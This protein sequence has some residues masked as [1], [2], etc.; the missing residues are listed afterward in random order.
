M[1]CAPSQS[2]NAYVTSITHPSS[3]AVPHIET[4]TYNYQPG[5][6]ATSVDQNQQSTA[7]TYADSFGRLTKVN[8][9]DGGNTGYTYN[10]AAT[11]FSLTTSKARDSN[12]S[13]NV[14]SVATVTGM[15]E[16]DE[17]QLTSDPSGTDE[18]DTVYDGLARVYTV[19]NPYRTTSDSTY[20]IT[21]TLYDALGRTVSVTKPDGGVVGSQYGSTNTVGDN[22]FC[23]TV[24]DEAGKVRETCVDGLGRTLHVI[25]DPTGKDYRTDYTYDALGNLLSVSQG[26]QPRT[27]SYDS[28]SRLTQAVNPESGTESYTYDLNG[29]LLTRHALL[30][31]GGRG[32]AE[33]DRPERKQRHRLRLF[34]RR[35]AGAGDGE[36]RLLLL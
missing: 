34:W 30:V 7:Y 31:R 24:T 20:G 4:F 8:Y 35:A 26:G 22:S 13:D 36:R 29:N 9:P 6:L 33:R 16:V 18:T 27:F 21:T 12:S 25:E 19:S 28:L 3:Y 15:G 2:T 32:G 23:T 5:Q 17:T 14:V 11:P 1:D 10:E